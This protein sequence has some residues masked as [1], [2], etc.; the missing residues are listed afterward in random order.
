MNNLQILRGQ[1]LETQL[2]IRTLNSAW[3]LELF[4]SVGTL[5]NSFGPIKDA[6]SMPYLSVHVMLR[7]HLDEFLKL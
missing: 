2:L 4:I 7:Q 6:V 1:F 3:D 5:S